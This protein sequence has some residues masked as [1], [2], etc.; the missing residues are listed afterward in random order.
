M[1]FLAVDR[2]NKKDK[3]TIMKYVSDFSLIL[4]Y[5]YLI[6][7]LKS[8]VD[9]SA[10]EVI[11]EK[12][13]SYKLYTPRYGKPSLDTTS[14]KICQIVYSM[15]A[16]RSTDRKKIIFS[17]LG[18]L[19]LDNKDD[20]NKVGII[21]STMLYA[22]PFNHP[23]NQMSEEFNLYPLRLIFKLLLDGRLNYRLY[24][25]EV[26]Y[27][28][29]WLKDVDEA[30]YEKLVETLIEFRKVSCSQ[31]YELFKKRL[32]IED[33]LANALHETHYL[34]DQLKC[35]NIVDRFGCKDKV[36]PLYHG[37]FGRE[38]IP[39]SLPEHELKKLKRSTRNYTKDYI[40]LKP[41]IR[42]YISKLNASYSYIE[43]PHDL[44]N[45]LSYEDYI[46]HLYNF[47]PNEL[48]EE[49]DIDR[50]S[51]QRLHA[52]LNIT[53]DI[54]KYALNNEYGDCYRFEDI[55]KDAFNEMHDVKAIKI[56]KAGTA[57]I[58]CIYLTIN[59]KFDVEAK[60]TSSKLQTISAGRLQSHRN[61]ISSKYTIIVTPNYVPSVLYD[62]KGSKNVILTSS[63]LSNYLYQ[64]TIRSPAI[65]YKP[66]YDL[67][68]SN[69]G[70]D[71]SSKLNEYVS[72]EFGVG[73]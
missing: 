52:M 10:I 16:Y 51:Q 45:E 29:M 25:D 69:F 46:L 13:E 54:K 65:S 21:F 30:S 50:T 9:A 68:Q 20:L 55:I 72:Y 62:I 67:V 32:P 71:I 40:S 24:S 35:S 11:N 26:F 64:S 15:L 27:Y 58:E 43:R 23:F 5:A 59:E 38:T 8:E 47:Y 66:I 41:Y 34:F 61:K 60:S 31:K 17:P 18:N 14:F 56:A 33:C 1:D 44:L 19:L 63:S 37:G 42:P 6:R 70:A 53:N 57:D 39:E 12:M 4:E 2:S 28:V 48:I 49:L 36:G 73:G 3:W 22:L 7:Q